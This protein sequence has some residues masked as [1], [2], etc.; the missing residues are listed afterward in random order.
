ML[1]VP[2]RASAAVIVR[3]WDAYQA[4]CG[5]LAQSLSVAPDGLQMVRLMLEAR[6]MIEELY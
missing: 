6:R 2:A 4:A 3:D 5:S 1:D